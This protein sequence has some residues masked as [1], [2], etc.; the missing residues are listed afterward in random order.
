MYNV[1]VTVCANTCT[2]TLP[3]LRNVVIV[4]RTERESVDTFSE[5]D[6]DI[7][8]A[9]STAAIN[10][11]QMLLQSNYYDP[12]E[13]ERNKSNSLKQEATPTSNYIIV[14]ISTCT[15]MLLIHN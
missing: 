1:R 8:A 13:D 5:I 7:P 10:L 2:C 15:T 6:V 9:Q 14:I 11:H 3:W 12:E 4:H